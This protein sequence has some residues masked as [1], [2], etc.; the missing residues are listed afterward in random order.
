MKKILMT[1]A[2][3]ITLAGSMMI[4]V[5]SAQAQDQ[6][7]QQGQNHDRRGD[8]RDDARRDD[9]GRGDENARG[10]RDR[11]QHW[12]DDRREVRWNEHEHNGYYDNNRW[13]Y[14]PPPADYYGHPGFSPGYQPW[15]RGQSLGYYRGRFAP[16]N[17]RQHNLRRPNRGYTWV[18]DD[19][20]DYLLVSIRGGV[21]A[22]VIIAGQHHG[23]RRQAWRDDRRDAHWDD[24]R[25]N[26]Y[27]RDNVWRRGPPPSGV[28][29]AVLG[30]QPWERG[31]R[32]GYYSDR[33]DE[34]D[35]RQ[36]RLRQPPRG[37]HWVRDDGGDYL[38]AAIVGGLIAEVILSNSR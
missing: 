11:R 7:A 4:G 21:I 33:Y 34:V 38:L 37:Y 6:Y 20:G 28:R 17:Y 19:R 15:V 5:A 13:Y 29:G 9:D 3:A 35:Y 18:Q 23:D 14:G 25:H 31:Q 26:G 12:R 10:H 36:H 8:N 2:A 22:A 32:L 16:V 24:G 30:Y 27:Y 1:T